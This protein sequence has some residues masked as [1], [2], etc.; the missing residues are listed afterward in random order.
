MN[1]RSFCL[2]TFSVLPC[3]LV[4]PGFEKQACSIQF[5]WPWRLRQSLRPGSPVGGGV[6]DDK[7]I[8]TRPGGDTVFKE[9]HLRAWKECAGGVCQEQYQQTLFV[10]IVTFVKSEMKTV[11]R[12]RKTRRICLTRPAHLPFC[13]VHYRNQSPQF[14]A[15]IANPIWG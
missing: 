7:H 8:L 15:A 4:H 10:Q 3:A 12:P 1:A 13:A 6:G 11:E 14:F 9:S 2:P 5:S